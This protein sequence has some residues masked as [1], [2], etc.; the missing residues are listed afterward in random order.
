M[1][2][3][4]GNVVAQD[5]PLIGKRAPDFT[6]ERLSGKSASLSDVIEGRK[7]ILFFFATWCPHCREQL[8]AMAAKKAEFEK[9]GVVLALVDIGERKEMVAKFLQAHGVDNDAFLDVDSLASEDYKVLG[10]PT[11][12]FVGAD[13]KVRYVEYGLPENYL[14]ILK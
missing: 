8:A 7:A 14:E 1:L 13:G 4:A 9:E 10:I 2:C 3:G 11:L 5:S 6:L 12:V